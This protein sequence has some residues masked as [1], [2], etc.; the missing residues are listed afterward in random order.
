MDVE[1][2]SRS[3]EWVFAYGSLI[4]NPEFDHDHVELT[5][6]HGFHRSF[7]IRSIRHR[8]TPEAP[9]VVLG[10]DRGG[11]CVGMVYHLAERERIE[12]VRVLYDREMQQ[13]V[14]VPRMLSARLADGRAVHALTF[15]ANR[16]SS[17][18]QRLADEEIVR[19]MNQC[20][21]QRGLNREYL[22]NTWQSL[23]SHGVRDDMMRR[24]GRLVLA[25][26]PGCAAPAGLSPAGSTPTG[27]RGDAEISLTDAAVGD[28]R[29]FD[30]VS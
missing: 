28:K 3:V 21:G 7:C 9:G 2:A 11:S 13:H 10:L 16:S 1:Q 24:L 6:I 23:E 30:T 5:R 14:Y 20:R 19:R 22:L 26:T 15:V 29:S 17:A 4:W 12:A 8:G 18:Y 25:A 27:S